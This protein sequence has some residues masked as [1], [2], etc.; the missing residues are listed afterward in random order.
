M[1]KTFDGVLEAARGL[2]ASRIAVAGADDTTV[3]EAIRLAEEEGL[4][5]SLLFGDADK[6]DE[7]FDNVEMVPEH[8]ETVAADEPCSAAI[9]AVARGEA[10]CVMKGNVPTN[11]LLKAVLSHD[12]EEEGVKGLLS[13]VAII[14]NPRQNRLLLG[15]DGGM[16]PF[17]DAEMKASILLNAIPVA[18]ALGAKKPL[19]GLPALMEDKGQ[20]IPSL[21]DARRLM[22]WHREGRF[23]DIEMDGPFGVDI[24]LDAESAA[25]KKIESACAGAVDLLLFP[26]AD[27][28]N[29]AIKMSLYY[30][31]GDMIGL[32]VGGITPVILVSRSHSARSKMI[33]IALAKLVGQY[34]QGFRLEA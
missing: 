2:P 9:D 1:I 29:I 7:A 25:H 34:Q 30:T 6:I 14:E 5:S 21:N 13:H 4:G 31:G 24:F 23:G 10:D 19:V 33:S 12:V 32:V 20:D 28:C 22:A 26:N 8:S 27:S 15:T 16:I 17:P 11:V 18:R 3:I